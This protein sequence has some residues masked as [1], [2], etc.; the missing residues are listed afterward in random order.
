[1]ILALLLAAVA[2]KNAVEAERAFAAK[3][4]TQGLWTAFRETAAPSASMFVPQ[5]IPAHDFLKGRKDP[6]LGYMWWPAEAYVSCDGSVAVVTGPSVLGRTRGY[7]TTIWA[8]QPDGGWKWQLDHGD[9]LDRPRP[10]GERPRVRNAACK[11]RSDMRPGAVELIRDAGEAKGIGP[12]GKVGE[13]RSIDGSLVWTWKT[14]PSGSRTVSVQLWDGAKFAQ[15][16]RDE[17]RVP[18]P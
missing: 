14:A 1:V 7:F 5:W 18:A 15:V 2:P 10:A 17:V 9:V 16:L 12:D 13:G 11:P 6:L 4:Q 3:A 8:R